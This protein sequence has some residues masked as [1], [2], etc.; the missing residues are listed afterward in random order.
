[1]EIISKL[2]EKGV[3]IAEVTLHVGAGTFL[4]VRVENIKSHKLHSVYYEIDSQNAK[5]INDAKTNCGRAIAVATTS[6]RALELSNEKCRVISKCEETDIFIYPSYKFKIVDAMIT[7][8]HLPK[9]TLFMLISAFSGL[10]DV[11]KLYQH[12]VKAS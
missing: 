9:S 1:E 12:A 7:N 3:K 4:P 2:R 10:E 11:K 6:L 8:F 5:I